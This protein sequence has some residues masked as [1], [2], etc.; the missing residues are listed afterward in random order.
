MIGLLHTTESDPGNAGIFTFLRRNPGLQPHV[1]VDPLTNVVETYL[2]ATTTA[3]ALFNA[4]GGVETNR[5]P[6]GVFQVEVVGRAADMGSYS[7]EWYANLQHF[8]VQWSTIHGIAY[9]FRT[10]KRRLSFDEWTDINLQGW[11][12][13]CHVPENNHWDPGTLDY[14][15]LQLR[16]LSVESIVSQLMALEPTTPISVS[17]NQYALVDVL[18]WLLEGVNALR[19]AAPATSPAAFSAQDFVDE[20]Y[21]RLQD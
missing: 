3:K 6:G 12:G 7:D 5:R 16:N 9:T 11:L 20:L 10:S 19:S 1:G 2:P 4:P 14:S 8:L 21:K 18:G 17:G 15:R 13:H